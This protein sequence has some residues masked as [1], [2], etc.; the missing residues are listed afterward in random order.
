MGKLYDKITHKIKHIFEFKNE[1]PV[2]VLFEVREVQNG[3]L[4]SVNSREW[5]FYKTKKEVEKEILQLTKYNFTI[6]KK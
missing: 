1:L 2:K 4:L 6:K 5:K 3:F